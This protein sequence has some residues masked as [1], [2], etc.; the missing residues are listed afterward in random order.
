M[1]LGL[2]PA[3]E[4]YRGLGAVPMDEWTATP[5][6][7]GGLG[8]R[9]VVPDHYAHLNTSAPSLDAPARRPT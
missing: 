2:N 3:T 1:P 6:P 8:K 4:F 9:S 5:W 7:A